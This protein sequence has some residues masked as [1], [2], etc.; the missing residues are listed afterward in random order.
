MDCLQK[1]YKLNDEFKRRMKGA[2][3]SW[4]RDMAE[5]EAAQ[6]LKAAE[7]MLDIKQ[8]CKLKKIELREFATDL[9]VIIYTFLAE[10]LYLKK[11]K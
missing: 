1:F 8:I 4:G 7:E 11:D 5:N 3:N 2:A 10:N 9:S 6:A